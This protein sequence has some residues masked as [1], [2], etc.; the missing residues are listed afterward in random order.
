ME[1]LKLNIESLVKFKLHDPNIM[2]MREH[3]ATAEHKD[4]TVS[5]GTGVGSGATVLYITPKDKT[6]KPRYITINLQDLVST[7]LDVFK[8][9]VEDKKL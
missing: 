8:V 6:I 5:I 4:Y 2:L 9:Y 7:T 1:K 3:I